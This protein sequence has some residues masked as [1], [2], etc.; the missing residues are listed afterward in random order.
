M[1]E[2]QMTCKGTSSNAPFITQLTS[3]KSSCVL[4]EATQCPISTSE[5][6]NCITHLASW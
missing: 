4:P 1:A 5:M 2:D 3:Y 6:H